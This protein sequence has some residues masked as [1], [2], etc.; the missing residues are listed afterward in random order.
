MNDAASDTLMPNSNDA[1]CGDVS[2]HGGGVKLRFVEF[3]EFSSERNWRGVFAG[4]QTRA[5]PI[6]L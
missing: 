1:K 3:Y 4:P 5:A 6:D 2:H